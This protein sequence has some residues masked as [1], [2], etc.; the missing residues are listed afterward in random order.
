LII[1]DIY[2]VAGREEKRIKKKVSSKKLI[3]KI[4]SPSAIY[5]PK[6]KIKG[7]LK[8]NLKGG[9]VV[10]IMGAGDIYDLVV[11]FSTESLDI[12]KKRGENK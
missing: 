2:D 9:E 1:A 12:G 10:I 3:E 8:K 4:N 5:L 11:D 6:G 7:F